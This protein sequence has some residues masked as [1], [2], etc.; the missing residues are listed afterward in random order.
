MATKIRTNSTANMLTDLFNRIDAGQEHALKMENDAQ[1]R[2]EYEAAQKAKREAAIE[3]AEDSLASR[4]R[5]MAAEAIGKKISIRLNRNSRF[6]G[7]IAT[8]EFGG[9]DVHASSVSGYFKVGVQTPSGFV[10]TF[11]VST[12]PR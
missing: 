11:H 2:G 4:G 8:C 1:Y 6:A 3:K 7:I 9:S 10:K 12:L 5:K